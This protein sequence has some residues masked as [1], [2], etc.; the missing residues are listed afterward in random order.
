MDITTLKSRIEPKLHGTSL[1]KVAGINAVIGEAAGK[2]LSRIDPYNTKRRAVIENA[3]YDRVYNYT[4]PTDIKGVGKIV[5]LRP[6]ADRATTDSISGRYTREFDIKKEHDTVT[7]ET[8]SNVK[9]LRLS[10]DLTPRTIMHR[11]DSLTLE[12]TVTG[13][14]DVENLDTNNLDHIS[15]NA[16][17]QFG[18]DGATGEGTLTFALDTPIDISDLEDL[19]A[20]FHWLKFPDVSRL[21]SVKLEWGSSASVYWHET[22]T[23][24]HDRAFVSNAWMLLRHE[25]ADAIEV[26]SP[27]E[28]DA[29]A[30]DHLKLTF[31]YSTGDSLANIRLDN[32]TAA[33]GEV[34]ELIYYSNALFTDSAGT[35]YKTIPTADSDIILL[36]DEWVN[37]LL[38]EVVL[39]L[40]QEIKGKD[41][42]SDYKFF[43]NELYRTNE[44]NPGLYMSY[45][46]QNPSEVLVHQEVYHEF[47]DLSGL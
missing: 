24:A 36:D 6:I 21:T 32:I 45:E 14:G 16:A 33:L 25:W 1:A 18:L 47:D 10:K 15:G 8:L 12:G 31:T 9:T 20:L 27:A 5:D 34:W 3:I 35:T 30:I 26:G 41:M 28:A 46:E 19:G 2:V 13:G 22:A 44:D 37:I 43:Y 4:A 23:A 17:I 42:A 11:C 29:E 39:T 7:I 40:A 38:Y